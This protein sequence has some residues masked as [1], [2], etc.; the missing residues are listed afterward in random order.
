MPGQPSTQT[1]L[2]KITYN[3]RR[4]RTLHVRVSPV[5][6]EYLTDA[7]QERGYK[8]SGLVREALQSYLSFA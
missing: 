3:Q 2:T 5:E 4:S 8:L 6:L 1:D 7:A